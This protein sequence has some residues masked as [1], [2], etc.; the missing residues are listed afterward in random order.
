[1]GQWFE[2]RLRVRYQETDAMGVV[3]HANY[4]TWFEVS[5]TEW[6]RSLGMPYTEVEKLGLMLPV[7]DARIQYLSPAR[8]DD[9]VVVRNRLTSFSP[10][11]MSF[12]Y[13]VAMEHEDRI[14]VTGQTNHVWINQQWKPVSFK[15]LAPEY[16]N[17]IASMTGLHSDSNSGR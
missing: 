3:F 14:L 4:L 7:V 11:R 8:Y 13:E 6:I 10:T 17:R 12:E 9:E 2:Y 16:Y 5:R 15:R 1:M